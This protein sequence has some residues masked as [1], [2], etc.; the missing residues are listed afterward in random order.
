MIGMWIA[1]PMI[2]PEITGIDDVRAQ[3]ARAGAYQLPGV[4]N[5]MGFL[6][7]VFSPELLGV[8]PGSSVARCPHYT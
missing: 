8:R 3:L 5:Q 7:P 2:A 1:G 6:A 4:R